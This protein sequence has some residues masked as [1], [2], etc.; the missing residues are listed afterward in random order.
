[1]FKPLSLYVGLR[2]IRAKR[3]N[4]FISFISL[5]SMIGIALGVMVLITVL[6]VMNGFDTHIRTK[7]FGMAPAIT[8]STMNNKL[9]NWESWQKK[10]QALPKVLAAAP[11]VAGQGLLRMGDQISGVEVQGILP[12]AQNRVIQLAQKV[13]QGSLDSLTAKSF[14]IV[15]GRG[16]ANNLG[17]GIGD[18]I[19]LFIPQ[20]T[21]SPAGVM[22]RY[23]RFTVSGIF[24][25]GE[26]FGFDTNLAFINLRDA[27][28]LFLMGEQVTGLV[29]KIQDLY[30]A[31]K[32]ADMIINLYPSL[33]TTDWTQS[34]GPLFKAIAL[35]KTMMFLIL[36]LIIAVAAFNLI[37]GL[38]MLVTDKQA[39]IAILR[40][41]GATPG[42]IMRI[43]MIQG[44]FI[45]I[46][47]TLIGVVGG[48]LL[49]LNVSELVTWLQTALHT[50][51]FQT[52]VYD[53]DALPSQIKLGDV[54]QI[55]VIA[56]FLSLLATLYPAWRA[57]RV[58]PAEA[59]RYE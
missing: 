53:L 28:A 32:M 16:V 26:G 42:M 38:V 45:G 31:P 17:V 4:H 30:Q 33:A 22:P 8:V 14:N 18:K 3:T 2:Y 27:Q 19:I 52:S 1:M 47:G 44:S 39:D 41:M 12:Q 7:V 55:T 46:V 10:L 54:I 15:L 9:A 21:V 50:Q 6:S 37:S 11:F 58:Q 36:I 34:Y 20:L 51:L 49:A 23:K 48:V 59:L 25:A 24:T 40:T 13:K 5:M 43:F 29:L 56:L 35:E 57:A